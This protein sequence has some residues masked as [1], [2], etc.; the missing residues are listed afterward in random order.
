[1]TTLFDPSTKEKL[2]REYFYSDIALYDRDVIENEYPNIYHCNLNLPFI[3]ER[4]E[5]CH[6]SPKEANII[7]LDDY[8]YPQIEELHNKLGIK[9]L[10]VEIVYTPPNSNLPIHSDSIPI[11][12]HVKLNISWGDSEKAR[13]RWWLPKDRTKP[14]D[15]FPV[16]NNPV[17]NNREEYDLIYQAQTNSPCLVNVGQLHDS[18]NPSNQGRWTL[19]H[20]LANHD[21]SLLQWDQAI[22]VYK[23]YIIT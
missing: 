11:D 22:E 14:S 9:T 17:K 8:R 19:S 21:D 12:N 15:A 2:A 1:M 16:K 10:I 6:G 7:N 18:Y 4:H 13:T 5:M 20:I 23:E 3:I